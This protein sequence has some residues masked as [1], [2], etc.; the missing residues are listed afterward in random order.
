[1]QYASRARSIRNTPIKNQGVD[2]SAARLKQMQLEIAQLQQQLIK[3]KDT[4]SN[5]ASPV[6][7]R[8][9]GASDFFFRVRF[10]MPDFLSDFLCLIFCL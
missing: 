1:M 8:D 9:D 3:Y 7:D 2:Q 5:A 10:F 6:P 4:R